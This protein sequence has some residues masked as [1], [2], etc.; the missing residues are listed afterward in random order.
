MFRRDQKLAE[1][2]A[3][4]TMAGLLEA[5][6]RDRLEKAL[7]SAETSKRLRENIMREVERDT[8]KK[9]QTILSLEKE[10]AFANDRIDR[11]IHTPILKR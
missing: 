4:L 10:L 3:K 5:N 9:D 6:L 7:V 2:Q 11:L 8:N 1:L